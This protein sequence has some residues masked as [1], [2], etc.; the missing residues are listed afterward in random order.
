MC[1]S[2]C[3]L[4]RLFRSEQEV[5]QCTH[6]SLPLP[7]RR[8][9]N[10]QAELIVRK[11]SRPAGLP[12]LPTVLAIPTA[13]LGML[14]S[15]LVLLSGVRTVCVW[16]LLLSSR[17]CPCP[18]TAHWT[19]KDLKGLRLG[20]DSSELVPV[21]YQCRGAWLSQS[22]AS[23]AGCLQA[24]RLQTSV[25]HPAEKHWHCHLRPQLALR[26]EAVRTRR[27]ISS[28]I[29]FRHQGQ[30]ED[31]E[32]KKGQGEPSFHSYSSWNPAQEDSA[33]GLCI[34]CLL[35]STT[36]AENRENQLHFQIILTTV[37]ISIILYSSFSS[38][39]FLPHQWHHHR[40]VIWSRWVICKDAQTPLAQ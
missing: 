7:P 40:T 33:C 37:I 21:W 25:P 30:R 1:I 5:P 9:G 11:S 12:W 10:A 6:S 32:R 34:L 14:N 19:G 23:C 28:Y 22:V 20:S 35:A 3:P 39:N 38:H 8:F 18:L 17:S 15:P 24:S 29:L 16:A 36:I 26:P 4:P 2:V 13:H 27:C 31:M